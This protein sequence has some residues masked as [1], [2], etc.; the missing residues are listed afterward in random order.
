MCVYE[1]AIDNYTYLCD[2]VSKI[3]WPSINCIFFLNYKR[4]L[5]LIQR[6]LKHVF[7]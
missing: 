7:V 5:S 6:T 4:V 1:K 3:I 2:S